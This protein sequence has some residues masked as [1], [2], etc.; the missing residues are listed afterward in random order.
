MNAEK[1]ISW[2]GQKSQGMEYGVVMGGEDSLYMVHSQTGTFSAIV[3]FSCVV[4]PQ[5][6][7][8]VMYVREPDGNCYIL[9]ILERNVRSETIMSFPGD[10]TIE[11]T[12]GH[13]SIAGNAGI[14]LSTDTTIDIHSSD[15]NV[16]ASKGRLNVSETHATGDTFS[17]RLNRVQLISESIDTVAKRATQRLKTCYRWVEQIEQTTA[18]QLIQKV[19]NLFSVRARQTAIT[20]KEDVK[21][22]GERIHLG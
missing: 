15:I 11:T 4:K 6:D 12:K 20:A 19:N 14:N 5:V 13:V 10:M 2:P 22:D 8:K 7:D 9:A 18:G 17:G 21:V 16:S 1:I 3:A